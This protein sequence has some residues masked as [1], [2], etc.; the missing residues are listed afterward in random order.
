[1]LLFLL[2]FRGGLVCKSVIP[3]G[4]RASLRGV[5]GPYVKSVII[6]KEFWKKQHFEVD[7]SLSP[8]NREHLL[9]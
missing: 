8:M 7:V 5:E 6:I 1:M 9:I 3:L 4:A 2:S